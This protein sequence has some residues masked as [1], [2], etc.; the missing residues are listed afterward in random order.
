MLF[1]S[2]ESTVVAP[3]KVSVRVLAPSPRLFPPKPVVRSV[4]AF[5]VRLPDQFIFEVVKEE[6]PVESTMISPLFGVPQTPLRFVFTDPFKRKIPSLV[7]GLE[8]FP[9]AEGCRMNSAPGEKIGRA[10]A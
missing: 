4:P 7:T 5:T 1:C 3:L 2:I 6:I 9:F 8:K 10:H